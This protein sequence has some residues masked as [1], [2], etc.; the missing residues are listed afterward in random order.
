MKRINLIAISMIDRVLYFQ[1]VVLINASPEK[2]YSIIPP[3]RNASL[4]GSYMSAK[5]AGQKGD[6]QTVASA[7]V[8]EPNEVAWMDDQ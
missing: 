3:D 1:K 5:I 6:R 8:N 7:T 2:L 4:K